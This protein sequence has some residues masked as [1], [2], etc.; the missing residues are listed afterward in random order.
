M[1]SSIQSADLTQSQSID[2]DQTHT[3]PKSKSRPKKL[4]VS[5][6]QQNQ[7]PQKSKRSKVTPTTPKTLIIGDSIINGINQRGL[8]NYVHCSGISGATV[9]T[10]HEKMSVYNLKNFTNVIIFIM[11]CQM[12][13]M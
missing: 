7:G 11:M 6:A 5:K 2:K 10:V 8:K 13:Q 1:S 4:G 3:L 12:V 9:E